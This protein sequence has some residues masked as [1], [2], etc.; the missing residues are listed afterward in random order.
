MDTEPP[1]HSPCTSTPLPLAGIHLWELETNSPEDRQFE[2]HLWGGALRSATQNAY[3]PTL[4]DPS[5]A[6]GSDD[7]N[8]EHQC[9]PVLKHRINHQSALPSFL[10]RLPP[11]CPH[12]TANS[13]QDQTEQVGAIPFLAN[14]RTSTSQGHPRAKPEHL[15]AWTKHPYQQAE[16]HVA[17]Q[18]ENWDSPLNHCTLFRGRLQRT[19]AETTAAR[20]QPF[21]AQ[22][23]AGP[24][25]PCS[26]ACQSWGSQHSHRVSS[27]FKASSTRDKPIEVFTGNL[28]QMLSSISAGSGEQSFWKQ[29]P[30]LH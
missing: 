18:E 28:P 23:C 2:Q 15:G 11:L 5:F 25:L 26:L 3:P 19:S 27:A 9:Y 21:P 24:C 8:S 14:A 1:E 29:A 22:V 7:L 4:R 10:L 17:A 12:Y 30:E 13:Q 16:A 6:Q 20:Q